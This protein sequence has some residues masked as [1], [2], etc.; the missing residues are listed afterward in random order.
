[1]LP[2]RWGALPT[3]WGAKHWPTGLATLAGAPSAKLRGTTSPAQLTCYSVVMPQALRPGRNYVHH[4]PLVAVSSV[5]QGE[6]D[7]EGDIAKIAIT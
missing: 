7:A 4:G 6:T 1:M 2:A 5:H 3:S